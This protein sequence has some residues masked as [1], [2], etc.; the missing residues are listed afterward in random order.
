M[1]AVERSAQAAPQGP[2]LEARN[3]HY[4]S[5]AETSERLRRRE[6]SPVEVTRACLARIE[7]LNPLINAFIT[8]LADEALESAAIAEAEINGGRWRGPLHGVPVGVKDLYDTAGIRTT[9]AFEHFT[10]RTPARDA[11]AV[12]RLRGAGAIIV[13]KANMHRLAMGTTSAASAFGPVRNPWGREYIAGGSS[14]G[15]AAAVACGMC[16]A[17]LDTDAIGSC[18]LPASCCG[19]TGLKGTYGLIDLTGVLDGEPVDEAI[20]WLAHAAVTARSAGDAMLALNAL[21]APRQ[22]P[23]SATGAR[24]RIGVV[25]NSAADKQTRRAFD[26]ALETLRGTGSLREVAAPLDDPGFDVPGIEADRRTIA[27]SLFGDVDVLALPTTAAVTPTI[28]D[29][30]A[31]PFALSP[32]NTR[33]ANYYGL[34][35][36]SVPSGFDDRGL[37]L[38]LQI[39]GRP[40]DE[41]TV[42]DLARQY[43]MATEWSKMRPME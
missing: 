10:T 26:A 28:A 19:V 16:Y 40:S 38:G 4:A 18:R 33:F 3:A 34:P 6:I 5:I 23:A 13:G 36:I 29:A 11:V 1:T 17:A 35:A 7:K 24:P 25:A 31:D 39:V 41:R 20:L 37:P 12:S 21:A 22:D 42:L 8:V 27:G 32:R 15:S 30:A 9:A 2:A 14:G 43:Q